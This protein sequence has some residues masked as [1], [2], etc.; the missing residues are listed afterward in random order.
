MAFFHPYIP[1]VVLI[2]L[3]IIFVL[4]VWNVIL[5]IKLKTL[6]K[7]FTRFTRGD[8]VHNLEQ[9]IVTYSEEVEEMKKQIAMNSKQITY[10]TDKLKQQK[11]KVGVLRYNA[12]DE[13]GSDMSFSVAFL[14]ELNNGIVITSIYNR[15]QSNTYAK[16]IIT[17]ESKYK[18]SK[19]ELEAMKIAING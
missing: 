17:G 1:M 6:K 3:G 14:D 18:L 8:Q 9:V 4:V 12:F 7:R 19:E 15:G 13:E 2:L 10:L 11:G 5:S 16:P